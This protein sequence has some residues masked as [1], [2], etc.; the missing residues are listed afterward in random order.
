M[1][2]LQI[3]INYHGKDEEI[4]MESFDLD[5]DQLRALTRHLSTIRIAD[6]ENYAVLPMKNLHDTCVRMC[7]AL[8]PSMLRNQAD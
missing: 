7:H 6:V 5:G 4:L 1:K 3:T 8:N 2:T